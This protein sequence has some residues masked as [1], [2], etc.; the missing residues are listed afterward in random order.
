[1]IY[2]RVPYVGVLCLGFAS[3][4]WSQSATSPSGSGSASQ[5]GSASS[6]T[7]TTTTTESQTGTTG[8]ASTGAGQ[9]A[10]TTTQA[11]GTLTGKVTAGAGVG[12]PNASITATDASTGATYRTMT[13]ADG[14]FSMPLPPGTYRVDVET[15]GLR[16]M[17]RQ[18]VVLTTGAP[19]RVDLTLESDDTRESV[20]VKAVSP[21]AQSDS[22]ER[23]M[24]FGTRTMRQMPIIDRNPQELV[25]LMSGVMP[26]APNATLLGD[27]QRNRMLYV[28][29]QPQIANSFNLDGLDNNEPFQHIATHVEPLEAIQ[30][31]NVRTANYTAD[32]GRAGGAVLNTLT[33]PGTNNFHG[34]AFAFNNNNL[35]NAR[36]YFNTAGVQPMARNTWN[37]FG[38]TV[39]GPIIQDKTFFF[40]S[41]E[42]QYH[43]GTRT[44]FASV[45]LD[46]WRAGNF[47][48]VAGLTLFNPGTGNSL[49][50]GRSPFNNNMIPSSQVNPASRQ[51]LSLFP[52]PNL[53]GVEN[54]FMSNAYLRNDYHRFNGRVD[55]H[56]SDRS[57]VWLRY[58]Y[59]RYFSIDE[60]AL[61]RALSSGGEGRLR[62]HNVAATYNHTFSPSLLSDFRF[63]YNRYDHRLNPF[64]E[65]QVFADQLGGFSGFPAFNI[66]GNQFGAPAGWPMRGVDN[67][68]N[69][70]TNWGWVKGRHTVKF[71]G[72]FRR[73]RADGWQDAAFGPAG[74]F[75][76]TPGA[77]SLN[78]GAGVGG[79]GFAASFASFL[80]GS[81][82]SANAAFLGGITP[83]YRATHGFGW[84][85]DTIQVMPRLTIDVGVRYEVYQPWNSAHTG[86][87]YNYN[88]LT[89]MVTLSGESGISNATNID[90]DWNNIAPRFGFAYRLA[91]G[92]VVRG[93]YAISYFPVPIS[94]AGG[95]TFGFLSGVQSGVPGGFGVGGSFS[96]LG[97]PSGVP[98]GGSFTPPG[99]LP[100]RAMA[101][102]IETP[103]VQSYNFSLQHEFGSGI[104]A[105]VAYVGTLG[106]HLPFLRELNAAAPGAGLAGMPLFQQFGRTAS[107]IEYGTGLN[108][109]Y[110]SLQAN[111]TKRFSHGL[112]L[113]ASYTWSRA[114][115]FASSFPTL[116]NNYDV[117]GTYGML[118]NNLNT[119][120]NYGPADYHR[121]HVFNF[122]HLWELPFGAGTNRWNQGWVGQLIGNWQLN[123][124][125]RWASGNRF[126]VFTDPTLCN[127]PGNSLLADVTGAPPQADFF[128]IGQVALSR[129]NFAIPAPGSFGNLGRNALRGPAFFTYDLSVFRSFPIKDQIK[130]E[131]RGE[132]YNLTNTPQFGNPIGNLSSS[133]F[134]QTWDLR[135]GGNNRQINLGARLV[136]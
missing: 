58:N 99:N 91:G 37:Q 22:A 87:M 81:P 133:L 15:G 20:E 46:E 94:I 122:S 114:L 18:D 95:N 128:D 132:A 101:G 130:L 93:A 118:I 116:T 65:Q 78:G 70:A 6:Q 60:S 42:G 69:W 51:I 73:I 76:F 38:G 68:F 111:L 43:R 34:S 25:G 77:V 124:I 107:T 29:G 35:F 55:H 47:S 16:R 41:Y 126:N 7:T 56:F 39:G 84:I 136:F 75:L 67:T 2:R 71:G 61:P 115:D 63:G 10:T 36:N 135:S 110:N 45:P 92:T 17:S 3:L 72:D 109:N 52:S 90:T 125:F 80:L 24:G 62:T 23:A 48:N 44:E 31:M 19:A 123:G 98:A 12:V 134:G 120:A 106:R 131:F 79:N 14:S 105:D 74:S 85:S 104:L 127:C 32:V 66:A 103:Y 82:T 100:L 96:G 8:S 4:M 112:A 97:A 33:R 53:P 64:A 49:G 21:V 5:S 102:D 129:N 86:G 54:N 50:A 40:G 28:N 113:Q 108:N 13:G 59:S 117:A 9:S 89:N 30:Q 26:P 1:M 11:G 57:T 83:T 121:Q 88:P 119:R 27:P